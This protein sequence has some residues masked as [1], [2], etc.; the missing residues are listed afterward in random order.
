MTES[1][2]GRFKVADEAQAVWNLFY[3]ICDSWSISGFKTNDLTS[4]N[5]F[6]SLADSLHKAR[7]IHGSICDEHGLIE[8]KDVAHTIALKVC[9]FKDMNIEYVCNIFILPVSM[10][11]LKRGEIRGTIFY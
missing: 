5:E 9:K 4:Q 6:D 8:D 2:K 1:N 7:L 3:R 11:W 10:A